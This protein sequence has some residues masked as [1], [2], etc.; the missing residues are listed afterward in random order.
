MQLNSTIQFNS[1]NR[2]IAQRGA[3]GKDPRAA[4]RLESNRP[5]EMNPR[6]GLSRRAQLNSIIIEMNRIELNY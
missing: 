1:S 3:C 6:I 5:I 4:W 2:N